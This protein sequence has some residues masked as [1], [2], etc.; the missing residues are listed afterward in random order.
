MT[1]ILLVDISGAVIAK[2]RKQEIKIGGEGAL[3]AVDKEDEDEYV[4][5]KG[6][7]EDAP[8]EGPRMCVE[9][10]NIEV[11]LGSQGVEKG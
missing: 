4:E 7:G 3:K 1:H 2:D 5:K 8:F 11:G 10:E 9:V 6:N